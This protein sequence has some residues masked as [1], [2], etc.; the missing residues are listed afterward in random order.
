MVKNIITCGVV[1]FVMMSMTSCD[2]KENHSTEEVLSEDVDVVI[3]NVEATGA[4]TIQKKD[5]EAMF[6]VT[7]NYKTKDI[8]DVINGIRLPV[9]KV[10][11]HA[12]LE[13]AFKK[14]N[15]FKKYLFSEDYNLLII[16][17]HTVDDYLDLNVKIREDKVGEIE[18]KH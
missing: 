11:F 16:R 4:D 5:R 14:P 6:G 1:S 9:N 13:T 2:E 15:V 12:I 10:I 8:E 17:I 18:W 3:Y 7:T